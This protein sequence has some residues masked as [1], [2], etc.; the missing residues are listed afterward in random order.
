ML[1]FEPKMQ[2]QHKCV[3]LSEILFCLELSLS[4]RIDGSH[5]LPGVNVAVCNTSSASKIS[6]HIFDTF[7]KKR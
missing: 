2:Q 3:M 4:Q 6:N 7:F 5:Y 1:R